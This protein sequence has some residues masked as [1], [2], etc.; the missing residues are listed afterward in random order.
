MSSSDTHVYY[1][2]PVTD[3]ELILISQILKLIETLEY[4]ARVRALNYIGAR[5][6]P[7]L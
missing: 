6:N 3:E 2:P 1:A 4:S 5:L 7:D